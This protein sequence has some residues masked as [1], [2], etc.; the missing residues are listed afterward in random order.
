MNCREFLKLCRKSPMCKYDRCKLCR[1]V[2][3]GTKVTCKEKNSSYTFFNPDKIPVVVFLV[4]GG[5]V[6][7]E[8]NCKKCDYIYDIVT[9][10]ASIAIF[11]EL[12]GRHYDDALEQ[13]E[14]SIKLFKVSFSGSRLHARIVYTKV[15]NINNNPQST[16]IMKFLKEQ[17][18]ILSKGKSAMEESLEDFV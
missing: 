12:K 17:N 14:N 4:D 15:P 8:E 2:N 11:I 16:K 13:I 10:D 9:P 7:N 1:K 6:C 5:I 3:N 18:V